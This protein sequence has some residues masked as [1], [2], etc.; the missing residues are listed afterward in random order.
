MRQGL[1][2]Q[3]APGGAGID[4][5]KDT[6]QAIGKMISTL[7]ELSSPA[8][9]LSVIARHLYRLGDDGEFWFDSGAEDLTRA[10]ESVHKAQ[11]ILELAT[12]KQKEKQIEL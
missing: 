9:V 2:T 3:T 11:I 1:E 5:M 8:K 10:A 6:E 12:L 7:M 4:A